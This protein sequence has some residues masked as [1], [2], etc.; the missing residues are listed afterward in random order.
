M[1]IM[2]ETVMEAPK[3]VANRGNGQKLTRRRVPLSCVACRVR[4]YVPLLDELT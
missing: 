3:R 1:T 2:D 4:K